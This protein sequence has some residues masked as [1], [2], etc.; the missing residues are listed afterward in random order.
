MPRNA[1]GL[2]TLPTP[3]NPV[4]PGTLIEATWA[5]TTMND[6]AQAMT[7]S[8]TRDGSGS[9]NGPLTLDA[10]PP[11]QPNQA[12]SKAYVDGFVAFSSGL[13]V[14]AIVTYAAG[15]A[16]AGYLLCNG[17][18]VSRATYADLFTL[19]GTS[20][21]AGDGSTTF[22]VPD[23]QNQF[24]RGRDPTAR[25]IGSTQPGSF[26]S[27]IHTVGNAVHTHPITDKQHTH[28]QNSHN[29]TA[30]QPPHNHSVVVNS[31]ALLAS[32][33]NSAVPNTA[34]V[35]GDAQPVITVVAAIATN[36][37]AFTGITATLDNTVLPTIGAEGGSETVPQ[38]MAF[39]L[40]IKA[41]QD[42]GGP[43]TIT[44]IASS[45]TQ[46]ISITGTATVPILNIKANVGYGTVKLDQNAKIPSVLLP[47]GNQTLLGLWDASTGQNPS[48]TFPTTIYA[49]GDTFIIGVNGT[50]TV[51]D[52][53][54]NLPAATAVT[55][56]NQILYIT[57][58]TTNPNGWY[59]IVATISSVTASQV[60]FA[61]VGSIT[62]TNVQ[63]GMQ[64]LDTLKA[65]LAS[66]NFTGTVTGVD[67]AMVTFTPMGGISAT[68]VQA[69]VEELDSE[70]VPLNGS[71]AIGTWGISISGNAA[72]AT[73][74]T[75]ASVAASTTGNSATA[76]T[77]SKANG[78]TSLTTTVSVSGAVAPTA[79][80]V[81]TASGSANA[82]WVSP[83]AGG[84]TLLAAQAGAG[85]SIVFSGLPA[86]MKR[87]T[88]NFAGLS[89]NGS[90]QYLIQMGASGVPEV[91]GYNA[92][93]ALL[94]AATPVVASSVVGFLPLQTAAAATLFGG[95]SVLT[96]VD[97][98]TN[99]WAFSSTGKAGAASVNVGAGDK[100]FSGSV[101]YLRITTVN[102]TDTFDA[103]KVSL[104]YEL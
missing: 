21:G 52:P 25:S 29:H 80:Q 83:S 102:G 75:N 55:V 10:A 8:V 57:G 31:G 70:K 58:S 2:Y 93:V 26:A 36:Q 37:N 94:N 74:A 64:Q 104:S 51:Y 41:V 96:L 77:A 38:N 15:S 28:I 42:S 40:Y 44:S 23:L 16:P 79:G 22:K 56:G 86:G 76:T 99:T 95:V 48:Q 85:A 97:A 32:G 66:P 91:T 46:M 19:I 27:H 73:N 11:T 62:A 13:P 18:A 39:D 65:P 63:A 87:I 9:M 82:S 12:V 50:I 67:A 100:V 101:N 68:D 90:S 17:Q 24:I 60:S 6:L 92:T 78:L 53:V 1:Q 89:S 34:G 98:A 35:T 54:T 43:T 33:N 88:L 4:Q 30:S 71:G 49:N 81:L 3:Q 69:A 45:D 14:G 20:F 84:L 47:A 72:T 5:N 103:G 59:Y 61:P 7:D